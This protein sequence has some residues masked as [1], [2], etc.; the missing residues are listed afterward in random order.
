MVSTVPIGT[1]TD[2]LTTGA[3]AARAISQ[4]AGSR[5][6]AEDQRLQFIADG[7]D[8][9][10]PLAQLGVPANGVFRFRAT[11]RKTWIDLRM[12]QDLGDVDK[13]V[14]ARKAWEQW[15]TRELG[16]DWKKI[17]KPDNDIYDKYGER[18]LEFTELPLRF[19]CFY[20]TTDPLIAAYI[21]Q[22]M[23]EPA[24]SHIFEEAKP[25]M[26]TLP[27]GTEIEVMPVTREGQMAAA[28]QGG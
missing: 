6:N 7:L 20:E 12:P 4:M 27:D 13:N 14:R 3:D 22:R 9:P 17:T 11:V 26:A 18:R 10:R 8:R 24:M 16:R 2:G 21:R 25:M 23:A 19:E 1:D 15:A 5:E 28:A